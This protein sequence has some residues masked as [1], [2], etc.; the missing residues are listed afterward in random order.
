MIA[1]RD[2]LNDFGIIEFSMPR[3]ASYC[4]SIAEYGGKCNYGVLLPV[5]VA[6][7]EDHG[8]VN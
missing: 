2:G 1:V 5:K 6:G 4:L 3:S 8:T 7:G